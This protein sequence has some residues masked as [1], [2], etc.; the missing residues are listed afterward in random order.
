MKK[1]VLI[2]ALL[3]SFLNSFSSHL[4]GGEI[5][6]KCMG[7]NHD[8]Y[9]PAAFTVVEAP[10]FLYPDIPNDTA[11][12]LYLD[13]VSNTL[14][15][16]VTLENP[17]RIKILILDIVGT[18]VWSLPETTYDQGKQLLSGVLNLDYGQ[19]IVKV[20]KNGSVYKTQKILVIK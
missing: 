11:A 3:F 13:P 5:T 17:A 9:T 6:L 2:S 18:L 15:L 12:Y 14:Y 19:Y 4:I 20:L 10:V 7:G 8:V 16:S 1:A